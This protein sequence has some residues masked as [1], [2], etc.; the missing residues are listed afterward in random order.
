MKIAK[1]PATLLQYLLT[2][3]EDMASDSEERSP[4]ITSLFSP[5]RGRMERSSMAP[6]ES[7]ATLTHFIDPCDLDVAQVEILK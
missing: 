1:P 3:E 5:P 2:I 6:T 4:S 7:I